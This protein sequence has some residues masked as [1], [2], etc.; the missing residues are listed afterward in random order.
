[1]GLAAVAALSSSAGRGET[2]ASPVRAES[3]ALF[4]QV[5]SVL[6]SRRCMNCHTGTEFPRQ[7]E[8][9]HP[10]LFNVGRGGDGLGAPGMH[11][12]TC[13]QATNTTASGVPGAP[14]WRLP[15]LSMAWE[16]LTEGQLCR[17]ILD[18]A[19]NGGRSPA[20]LLQHLSY[21][22]DVVW[23]WTPG[24][25][26]AGRARVPPPIP[27]DEFAEIVGRW[28]ETGAACPD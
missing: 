17:V 24:T 19:R 7:G 11:C 9:G 28:I 20:Q 15:P 4:H 14:N 1:V 13:H 3:V 2:A 18:P 5:H 8:D 10:H 23:A 6:Q 27:H 16:G 22:R 21:D 26:H 25:D 12:S